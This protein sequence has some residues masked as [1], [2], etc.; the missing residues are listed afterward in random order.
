M[1][2]LKFNPSILG[3]FRIIGVGKIKNNH[4]LEGKK[5]SN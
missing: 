4:E 3:S 1:E 5:N 2:L